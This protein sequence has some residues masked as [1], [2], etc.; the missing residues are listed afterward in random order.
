MCPHFSSP[1]CLF[2]LE[3]A[4]STF[5]LLAIDLFSITSFLMI[6]PSCSSV[7]DFSAVCTSYFYWRLHHLV[8][9]FLMYRQTCFAFA[10][11]SSPFCPT[12]ESSGCFTS[13]CSVSFPRRRRFSLF[14]SWRPCWH[15]HL[16]NHFVRELTLEFHLLRSMT[17]SCKF[18]CGIAAF[19]RSLRQYLDFVC[20]L[21][22]VFV[23]SS[24][25]AFQPDTIL[26]T[27]LSSG[28]R[29]TWPMRLRWAISVLVRMLSTPSWR[30]TSHMFTCF[31]SISF[32]G[33]LLPL[34]HINLYLLFIAFCS[35]FSSD[36]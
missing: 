2:F 15:S 22:L 36:L 11:F 6:L 7:E 3:P 20:C 28:R 31:S 26:F 30:L 34:P 13:T 4:H 35:C 18:S 23:S 8:H 12:C 14:W 10:S 24:S 25:S 21:V 27:N 16:F 29:S 5:E 17:I 19:V 9:S 1:I 32:N 33:S